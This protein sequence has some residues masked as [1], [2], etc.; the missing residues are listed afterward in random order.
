MELFRIVLYISI[1]LFVVSIF[2]WYISGKGGNIGLMRHS[3]KIAYIG[4]FLFF[5]ALLGALIALILWGA[6]K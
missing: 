3:D 1:F 4:G 5:T 6:G 2:M